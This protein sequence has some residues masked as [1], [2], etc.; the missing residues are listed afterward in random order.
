[1]QFNGNNKR[2]GPVYS[3]ITNSLFNMDLQ[4]GVIAPGSPKFL[5]TEDEK[6]ITTEDGTFITTEN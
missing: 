1:M 5:I 6:Y 4:E 3:P 2:I